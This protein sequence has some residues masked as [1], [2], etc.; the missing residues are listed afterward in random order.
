MQTKFN[1]I[2]R[3]TSKIEEMEGNYLAQRLLR[4]WTEEFIDQDTG[5]VVTVPRNEIIFDKGVFIDGDVL[6]QINFFLQS[7][8]IQKVLVS[9]QKRMGT[10]VRH[11]VI[12]PMVLYL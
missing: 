11:Q 1:E 9:N 8:D 3:R 5:E 12:N 4:T 6:S 7:G 10:A 2:I